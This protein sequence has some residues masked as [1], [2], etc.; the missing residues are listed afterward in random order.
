MKWSPVADFRE[1][2]AE[3]FSPREAAAILKAVTTDSA[4]TVSFE[5]KEKA[6]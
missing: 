4:P 5:T 6:A 1:V 2:L 3:H